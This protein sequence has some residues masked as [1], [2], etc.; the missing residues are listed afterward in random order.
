[1]FYIHPLVSSHYLWSSCVDFSLSID[2]ENEAQR[3]W[4]ICPNHANGKGQSHT[5]AH[6]C[7]LP[8]QMFLMY[9]SHNSEM[10]FNDRQNVEMQRWGLYILYKAHGTGRPQRSVVPGPN[11]EP[12]KLRRLCNGS[13]GVC[14]YLPNAFSHKNLLSSIPGDRCSPWSCKEQFIKSATKKVKPGT[15]SRWLDKPGRRIVY[16]YYLNF[17][18][19]MCSFILF[20]IKV[21]DMIKAFHQ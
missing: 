20:I 4:V 8:K 11:R 7:V 21:T 19:R 3:G 16:Y 1:M 13:P 14:T 18:Q 2:E 17:P 6:V 5:P 10:H 15:C 9:N 12:E